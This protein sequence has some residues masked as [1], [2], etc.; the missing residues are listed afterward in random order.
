[1][2]TA[3]IPQARNHA[4]EVLG[5]WLLHELNESLP[6]PGLVLSFCVTVEVKL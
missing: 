6:T 5:E 4:N 3:R 2:T 1:M